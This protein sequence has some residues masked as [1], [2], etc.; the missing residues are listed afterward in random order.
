M[1]HYESTSPRKHGFIMMALGGVAIVAA[2]AI[3]NW[4][5]PKLGYQLAIGALFAFS[6]CGAYLLVGLVEVLTNKS[7]I[8]WGQ[9]WMALKGWQRGIFGTLFL[10]LVLAAVVCI[11]P[12]VA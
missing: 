11:I 8:H 3:N 10:L 12:Y 6:A 5:L 7:F 2:V 9:K 4:L 1:K